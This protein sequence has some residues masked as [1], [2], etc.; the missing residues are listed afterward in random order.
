MNI[1]ASTTLGTIPKRQNKLVALIVEYAKLNS[2]EPV[3]IK[4]V[5]RFIL[6]ANLALPYFSV[7][8]VLMNWALSQMKQY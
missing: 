5:A 2:E 3:T 1:L 4:H 8:T 7:R 6:C